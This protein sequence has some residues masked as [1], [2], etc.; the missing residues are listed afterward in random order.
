M[1][2]KL[3]KLVY[4]KWC[5]WY[6]SRYKKNWRWNHEKLETGTPEAQQSETEISVFCCGIRMF[7]IMFVS[8]P[9]GRKDFINGSV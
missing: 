8:F 6:K 9:Y 5:L 2:K 1:F 4:T 3:L 7:L